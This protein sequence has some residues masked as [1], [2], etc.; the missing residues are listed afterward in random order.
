MKT[1]FLKRLLDRADK[2]DKV[3]ILNYMKEMAQERDILVQIFDNMGEGVLFIDEA[4]IVVYV[5]SAARKILDLGPGTNT[6]AIPFYRLLENNNLYAYW[7]RVLRREESDEYRE[8]TLNTD[9]ETRHLKVKTL[10]LFHASASYGTLFLFLDET[11]QRK[12][13]QKLHEAEKLAAMTTLAAGVS[14]EIRNPLNSLSIHMQLLERHLKKKNQK[15]ETIAETLQIFRKEIARLNEV[16]ESFLAAVRPSEKKMKLVRL[17]GLVTDTLNLMEPEF[18][19][20]QIQVSLH[21]DGEWPLVEVDE[22]QIKQAVINIMKNA[23]DAITDQ[24]KDE[25]E[26]KPCKVV[27]IMKRTE[28][29]VSLSFADTGKGMDEDVVKQMFQP[30]YT[31]KP[32]GTGLGMMIAD[33]IVREHNGHIT[34][35]SVEGEGTQITITLPVAAEE[36]RLLEHDN[37]HANS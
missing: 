23:I 1:S 35:D 8:I 28:D 34:A 26:R 13:Q 5:N 25:K 32:Q 31:S 30:Y 20:N 4:E 15:D 12:Q 33:R 7:R 3:S 16:I 22:S 9:E 24:P 29:Q 27:I 37:Q 6:P 10:H 21:E 19:Q 18:R 17:Y 14:H 2:I 11:E 36:P